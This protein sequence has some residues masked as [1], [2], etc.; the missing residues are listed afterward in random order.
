MA[1]ENQILFISYITLAAVIA[2]V[3]GL[4]RIFLLEK[5]IVQ[6]EA[7][8]LGKKRT[9]SKKKVVKKKRKKRR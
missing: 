8:I 9:A 5:K 1:V 6:L 3:Y 2:M 4:R 7:A